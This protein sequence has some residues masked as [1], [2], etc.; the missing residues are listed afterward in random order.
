MSRAPDSKSLPFELHEEDRD[1]LLD[2]Y[3]GIRPSDSLRNRKP[4]KESLLFLGP[5][6]LA[7][8]VEQEEQ[9]EDVEPVLFEEL[10]DAL[11]M[12]VPLCILFAGLYVFLA[13]LSGHR[14]LTRWE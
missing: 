2:K 5:E 9:I 6:E 12:T 10:L 3:A 14:L 7:R 11:L 1:A 4:T 8:L 13:L